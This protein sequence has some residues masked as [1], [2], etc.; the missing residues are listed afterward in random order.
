[1]DTG[2]DPSLK[3]HVTRDE[4]EKVR[5]IRQS[6]EYWYSEESIPRLAAHS[7]VHH[8]A[9]V[10]GLSPEELVRL[11]TNV[12]YYTPADLGVEYRLQE[13]KQQ[14]DSTT[15]GYAQTYLNLPVWRRGLSVTV[16]Q[17]PTRVVGLAN[18]SEEGLK[19]ELP[20]DDAIARYRAMFE[21]ARTRRSIG[22]RTET[23]R[24]AAGESDEVSG[25]VRKILGMGAHRSGDDE[26]E[27]R[28]LLSGKFFVYKY[29]PEK[30]FQGRA[31]S[32]KADPKNTSLEDGEPRYPRI[33]DVSDRI[34][35]GRAYVVAELIFRQASREYGELVWLLLVEVETRSILYIECMTC[36]VNGMVF[37]RDP[38]VSS[39]DLGITSA[40]ADSVLEDH[41]SDEVLNALAAPVGGEQSLTGTFVTIA[42]EETPTVQA[43]TKP[44]GTDFDY[45]PRTNDFAAVNAY[46]HQTE[47]FRTIESLGFVISTYFDGTTFPIPVDHRGIGEEIDAHWQ[48]DGTGG[49]DHMCYALCDLTNTDEPL[50]RAVDPWVHWHEM[51]GH[52]TLGDHVDQGRLG[53]SHSAGDGLAAI[54]MDPDSGLRAVPDRFRYAPFRPDLTR[55]FDRD[56]ATWG[57]GS[58][59]DNG[60]YLSEQILAT[61]HFRLY[62][63]IGGDHPDLARRQFA[64]RAA[65]YLILRTIADLTPE[66][67]PTNADLWADAMQVTDF[68]DWTSEGLSG[69]AY[70]KVVRWAFEEQGAYGGTPPAV[71]VYIDDGRGGEYPFQHAHWSNTSMW[72]RNIDDGLPGH[73]NATEGV[74][75]YMYVKIKNRG[76]SDA[77][78]VTVKGYHSLPGAGL[79]WPTDFTPMSPA[80]GLNVATVVADNGAEIT[81]GPFEWIPN[82]NAYGH[83]CTLMIVSTAGDPSNVDNFTGTDTIA[84]WRLVPNDNNVGQRNVSIVPGE[85]E[86]LSAS[87]E[88]ATFWAGN[89]FN[90]PA[91]MRFE[92]HVPR[93]LAKRGWGIDFGDF[94]RFELAPGEKIAVPLRLVPGE[95]FTPDDVAGAK[96]LDIDVVL[97]ANDILLGGMKYRV[98]PE[99]REP[100]GGK[101]PDAAHC[102]DAAQALLECLKVSG[103][104]VRGVQLRE[105]RD[106]RVSLDVEIEKG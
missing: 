92:A 32:P 48:Y 95:N 10:L 41:D 26:G 44:T 13:E 91:L 30:R 8:V 65:T 73:Q 66:T 38:N 81:V 14:F 45:A 42:E 11:D 7:Y 39:G 47:L 57:W 3:A 55:R 76:T 2:Y 59:N 43:P 77:S 31:R 85:S 75:N 51:G 87:F 37:K 103:G 71:D 16:K 78:D 104:E 5:H 60:N 27:V 67:N 52:G 105:V 9:D 17:A 40:A 23:A 88:G 50:G 35:P 63:S 83:D 97:Y 54:Q 99:L 98:D 80:A 94:E 34:E 69:G 46:Y 12:D 4:G 96:D 58:A 68:L 29:D 82:Y 70:N 93:P 20:S 64:S 25:V 72:N 18:N 90:R 86:A 74:T 21:A 19:G 100:S 102:K 61:C 53:F 49:T 106:S 22:P 79:T 84:E 1:M 28:G 36:G 6:Q 89:S 62:R 56:P 101:N 15:I 33:P 24:R